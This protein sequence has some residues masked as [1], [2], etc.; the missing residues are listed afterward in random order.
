MTF[1]ISESKEKQNWTNILIAG[2]HT[3][4]VKSYR[5]TEAKNAP[6][7]FPIYLRAVLR[8][9]N[10]LFR[11]QIQLWIFRVP[12]TDPTHIFPAYLKKKNSIKKKNL[13]TICHFLFHTTYSPTVHTVLKCSVAEP[14]HYSSAPAPDIFFSAPAPGKKFRLRLH[15]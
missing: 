15:P 2:K 6:V 14:N 3:V 12:D 1:Q 10:D 9:K 11:I 13:L 7:P 4:I 5:I 8:I